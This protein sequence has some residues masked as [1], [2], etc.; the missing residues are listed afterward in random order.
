MAKFY[1]V[2]GYT[3]YHETRPG[4]W[5]EETTERMYYGDFMRNTRRLEA[6]QD[7]I[8]DNINLSNQISIV[9]DPFAYENFS[10]MKYIE[11]MGVKWKVSSVEVKF[12]RLILDI[13]GVYNSQ[14]ET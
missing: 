4:I 13:G 8:N 2:I 11:Y 6:Q 12:P 1:G 3:I 14:I 9:A 10:C 7:N 5:E